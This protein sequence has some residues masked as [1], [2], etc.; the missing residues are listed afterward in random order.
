MRRE[1]SMPSPVGQ[2]VIAEE[3]GAIVVIGWGDTSATSN[4][5]LLAEA[6]RQLRAYFA[7]S[8]TEFDLPLNPAGSPFEQSVWRQMQEIP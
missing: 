7:G 4:N 1:R 6:E 5:P 3:D 8:L 2:L